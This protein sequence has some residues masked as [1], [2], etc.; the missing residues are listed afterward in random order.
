MERSEGPVRR[1]RLAGGLAAQWVRQT[2]TR[3]QAIARNVGS[4]PVARSRCPC[5]K[6]SL[7]QNITAE[8][9]LYCA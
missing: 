8:L 4:G 2:I 5:R 6:C 1:R 7:M 3:L 9:G